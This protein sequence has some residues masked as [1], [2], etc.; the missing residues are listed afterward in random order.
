M[1][2]SPGP[3]LLSGHIDHKPIEGRMAPTT[4]FDQENT[5]VRR[6]CAAACGS[7]HLPHH[8]VTHHPDRCRDTRSTRAR[9]GRRSARLRYTRDEVEQH[10]PVASVRRAAG[11]SVVAIAERPGH[12]N[13]TLVLSTYGHLMPNSEERT[14]RAIESAWCALSVPSARCD[15]LT[16]R[17]AGI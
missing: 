6:L 16:W 15:A 1:D 11:E 2:R 4:E 14:I 9:C 17:N 7:G 13:A 5:G 3:R 12:N 8:P 10:H